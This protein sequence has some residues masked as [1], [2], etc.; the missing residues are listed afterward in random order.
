MKRVVVYVGL[1]LFLYGMVHAEGVLT[2]V[3]LKD[4]EN[5]AFWYA[6]NTTTYEF[7]NNYAIA[8]LEPAQIEMLS[9]QGIPCSLIDE[10]PWD[11]NYVI[12]QIPPGIEY[13]VTGEIL[14]RTDEVMLIE[15]EPS[16]VS[17]LMDPRVSMRRMNR[18]PLPARFWEQLLVK[19][20]PLRT[21]EWDPFV[22][23][24]V[25][26]V[27]T[28]SLA[29]YV[30]RM[31]DFV[32]RLIFTD[33]SFAAS[34]WILEKFNSFGYDAEFDSVYLAETNYGTWPDTGYERNVVATIEGSSN[35]SKHII[36]SGHHDAIIWPDTSVSWTSAPGADDNASGVACALEAARIFNAY[37]WD[38]TIKFIGWTA[39]EV[40]LLGSDDY[41][42]RADSMG[43]DIGAVINLDMIGYADGGILD[44]NV[45][46]RDAFSEWLSALYYQAGQL[47][48]PS[49]ILY[50]E[51]WNGGSDDLSFALRGYPAIWGAERWYYANPHWHVVTDLLSNINMEL[52]TG[53]T[54]I[55][56]ATLA[57]LGIHPAPVEDV[58]A[59][60]LGTG[61]DLQITWSP[62]TEPDVIGY[63]IYW[64]TESE[65]YTDTGYMAGAGSS[66][67]T[68]T[69][70]MTDSTYYIIVRALDTDDH[71][72][73][74]ANEVSATP[75]LA[76]MAPTG[77]VATPLSSGIRI[78]WLPN[79]EIDLAGYRLYRRLDDNP[80]YD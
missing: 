5:I 41:A 33:S 65:V 2:A 48:A 20:I 54:K 9:A 52:L 75:R 21:L 45:H 6:Q 34:Q 35:P 56:I 46:H 39:E 47:Y 18:T 60:D 24:I 50:E 66:C 51:Y 29:S 77:V 32:T 62:N 7:I 37:N 14:W 40:G 28:D 80:T 71:E 25:D 79:G 59:S 70:L 76:P 74:F 11:K 67:D 13:R 12:G 31:Q 38:P 15:A 68:L 58:T 26:Q 49:I 64:G 69:G 73:Y 61:T 10:T 1:V 36:I 57:I 27:S 42:R 16:A 72:S 4:R 8:E 30:Q 78:D 55:A 17:I 53:N 63:N 43:M 19:R 22:Q 3:E 44:G 23:S